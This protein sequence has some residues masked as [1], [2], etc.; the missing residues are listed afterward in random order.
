MFSLRHRSILPSRNIR[1]HDPL[2]YIL[3]RLEL[4]SPARFGYPP[5]TVHDSILFIGYIYCWHYTY[6]V[7]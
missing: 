1:I 2:Q 4:I 3:E 7:D 6:L 5:H